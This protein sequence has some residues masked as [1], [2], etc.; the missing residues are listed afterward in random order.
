MTT[1]QKLPVKQTNGAPADQGNL[2][3]PVFLKLEDLKVLL[4]GGGKV[5]AEKLSAILGN[6][7]A[8]PVTV[9]AISISDE[10]H[11]LAKHHPNVTLHERA[12]VEAD[13]ENKDLVVI[14]VNEKESSLAIRAAAKDK[15]I[16][17][18]VADTPEQCDFYLSSIVQKGNLKIAI[19]TNGKS[20]TAAKRI[21]EVLNHALPNELDDMINNL[22]AVRNKLNGNFEYKVKRLNEITRIL[23]EKDN[24]ERE[25]R[26]RKI[27]TYSLIA[28]GLMLIGHFIFSY[29]PFQRIADDT[30]KWYSHL[31]KNFHWMLL[32]GFLAQ[33][34]DGALG[35]GY[36][37]TSATILLTA[38]VSPAAMSGSIHTAEM[39]AS[40]ASGYSHY[41]FGNVNKKLFK[42][43]VI[44]GV[45]GAVLGAILLVKFGDA[46]TAYIKPVI[47]T[48]TMLLGL[49]ILWNAFKKEQKK[50]K[51]KHYGWLAA[52]GG[53]LDSFG[54][55]GWGP[56]VTTTLITKGRSP[57]FVIGSVSL[58]EFFVTLASA[59]S[60][61]FMLG[62]THWQVIVALILGGLIAAPVAARLAG[63]LPRKTSLILLGILV[64]I[65]SLKIIVKIF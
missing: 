58:T 15:K 31:D 65:W 35:M 2:L 46:Q 3:F 5:G 39:F 59:F 13:L 62:V 33:L 1:E 11:K 6:S 40:G 49:R 29:L 21:K 26:W 48:Y 32:A 22:H 25:R 45:I 52:F 9:V 19:S 42:A 12:F 4:V 7:P 28:F 20:P 34:V 38:G 23:V 24:V 57:R 18:N 61:F 37:V 47:A 17:V 16:L 63:K 50:K 53:F 55:G 8:A 43:L 56:I 41:K 64:V 36:G 10:V 51:F 27:A 60:F 44:P 14:A 30:V 54:G